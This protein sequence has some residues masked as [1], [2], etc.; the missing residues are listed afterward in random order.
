MSSNFILRASLEVKLELEIHLI[1]LVYQRCLRLSIVL[2]NN[3]HGKKVDFVLPLSMALVSY[4]SVV[5][6]DAL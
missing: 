6:V 4:A 3:C 2:E 5:N 1:S